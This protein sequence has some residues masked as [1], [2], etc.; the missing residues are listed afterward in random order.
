MRFHPPALCAFLALAACGGPRHQE[1]S[2]DK[3]FEEG[4]RSPER[5]GGHCA[6]C[7]FSVYDGHRCGVTTPCTLC[8]REK[9]FRHLHEIVWVCPVDEVVTAEQHECNDAKSCATC[10]SDK[11]EQLGTRGCRRCFNQ[12]PPAKI[13]GITSYCST[14]DRE[15]GAN[16]IH[17]RTLYCR[18]CLREAGEGHKHDA[19]RLCMEHETEHAPDHEC[20]TTEYCKRCHRDAGPGHKHGVTEWCWRCGDEMEWPHSHHSD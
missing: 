1:V 5:S 7:N 4:V 11:R 18:T 2:V 3:V 8:G 13:Q 10:R 12:A 16:H 15:I 6:R 9:G 20:G 19:T 14:C 17:G